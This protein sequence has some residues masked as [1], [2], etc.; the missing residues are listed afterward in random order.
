MNSLNTMLFYVILLASFSSYR[1]YVLL[2]LNNALFK[3]VLVVFL[4]NGILLSY[5][6]INLVVLVLVWFVV[7]FFI[8]FKYGHYLRLWF[9][10]SKLSF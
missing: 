8:I 7:L 10:K 4:F 6:S 5:E 3:R 2:G 1:A 9:R